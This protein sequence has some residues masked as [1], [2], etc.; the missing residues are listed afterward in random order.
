M[1]QLAPGVW[2]LKG[3]PPNAINVYLVE[4]VLIDAATRRA[5]KRILRQLAGHQVNAHA[6][7]HAHPD[8]Q[9]ASDAICTRLGIP[10]W[11]GETD[12]PLAED[13]DKMRALQPPHP[14]NRL[15][16]KHWSGPARHVD[17]HLHEGDEVAG[18]EVLDVPGHSPGHLAYWRES[19][20]V[21]ILGDVLNN[22]DVVTGLPGLRDPK[23]FFTYDPAQNRRSAKRLG[24]LEPRL[25]LFGHGAPLRDTRKF[26]DFVNALPA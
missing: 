4:D 24:E 6:L 9:G 12:V 3:F 5:T 25:V 14:L 15:I 11:V 23:P 7:T 1:K 20:R 18:F 22:M 8:H 2:Q 13:L 10:Y 19:D 17:R 26:V 16:M 21:L